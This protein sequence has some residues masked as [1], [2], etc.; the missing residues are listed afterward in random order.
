ME[1]T[2][3]KL[4]GDAYFASGNYKLPNEDGTKSPYEMDNEWLECHAFDQEGKEYL[5]LWDLD[6]DW[7]GLNSEDACDWE[8]PTSIVVYGEDGTTFDV[9]AKVI[10]E[11]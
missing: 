2:K 11:S 3:I 6:P 4:Y 7:D 8:H 9:S 10:I 5:V 1:K